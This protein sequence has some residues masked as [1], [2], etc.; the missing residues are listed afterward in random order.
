VKTEMYQI[1][2]QK[3]AKKPTKFWH[4]VGL[5]IVVGWFW[6][7]GAFGMVTLK[8]TVVKKFV[9]GLNEWNRWGASNPFQNKIIQIWTLARQVL[10]FCRRDVALSGMWMLINVFR[11]INL[12]GVSSPNFLVVFCSPTTCWKQTLLQERHP[13]WMC[14]RDRSPQNRLCRYDMRKVP[15]DSTFATLLKHTY[16]VL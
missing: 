14:R 8:W 13:F 10:L 7:R 9:S 1:E 5:I 16:P 2:I 15:L 3:T 4:Q 6:S 12:Y 11:S